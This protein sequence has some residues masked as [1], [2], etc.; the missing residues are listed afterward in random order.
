MTL[1]GSRRRNTPGRGAAGRDI[2]A[3]DRPATEAGQR[4]YR[5]ISSSLA[6]SPTV[7]VV[8]PVK[9]EA[10]N[11]PLVLHSL[12]SWVNEVV[13]VDGRSADDTIAVAHQCRPDI[14]ILTQP[15]TG[16]GD[17]VL[18][19]FKACTGD[20]IVMMDGDGSTKGGEIIRFVGA[21]VAGAD[22]VKGSRFASSGGS[23]DITLSRRFGNR[24][25]SGLVNLAFGTQYTDLCYGFNALWSSH[26]P[27]LNLDCRGFEI[28]TLMNI[29]AAKA[30]LQVQEVPSQEWPRV[31]GESNLHVV[32]DGW[33]ILKV[34][35]GET[36]SDLPHR[37]W[38]RTAAPPAQATTAG[39]ESSRPARPSMISVVICAHT[40]DRLNETCA[41]VESA[42]AQSFPSKEIIVVV[43]H[44]PALRAALAAALPDVTVVENR[45]EPGLSGGKN[46][47]VAI[48]RG[49]VV[50][51]LDDDA[52]ADQ[53]W[54]KFL[55]DSYTDPAV[56]GVG[57]LTLPNWKIPR[58]S[59]FP[60]EFD[61]VV[62]CTY[63]GMPESRAPVRNL[64]GGNASFRREAFQLAGGFQ[65][66]I[67][68]SAG[69]RPLGCEET[70]FCIRLSQ[71]SPESVLLFDDRAVIRHLVPA[72]RCRFS[73]FRSRCYAEGLS[74][75]MVTASV[76]ASHGLSS[77]R[78][79][80][81][82]TLPSGV[83]RGIADAA[84]GSPSG[85]G[86]AGAI[87]A[88][89][90]ATTAGYLAGSLARRARR[91]TVAAPGPGA[92]RSSRRR[93]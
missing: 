28:E 33:R 4:E 47:G 8:I 6:I 78:R 57:G 63:R 92:G 79:Y 69:K 80:T 67:G 1:R 58:P 84:R 68:R 50:A 41:A 29:R 61:W 51:F 74:K 86:R 48:A 65:N 49:S 19:G 85:L 34:I 52:V 27:A 31:H 43:D 72:V 37:F 91:L 62:G 45:E 60:R 13:L 7:S 22:F 46:T 3:M 44:N 66:G 10:R 25:L 40:Q 15:G 2:R 75:A 16:K 93:P 90:A 71:K 35:V 53:D 87:V 77:E 56:M 32:V 26:L 21:L 89:L 54:L 55:A 30:L 73:Y 76:G 81:T 88:G 59:W 11:L 5:P 9:N 83:A 82:R 23:D 17:A 20:I 18:A 36:V 64:L 42:Q 38:R 39:A 24:V 12:P 14:K 70:E